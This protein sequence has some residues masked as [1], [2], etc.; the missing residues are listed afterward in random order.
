MAPASLTKIATAIY[1][2][3]KGNLEDIVTISKNAREVEGTR[4]F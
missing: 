4:V 1:A 2:I 3:E